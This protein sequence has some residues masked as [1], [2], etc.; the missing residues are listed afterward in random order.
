MTTTATPKAILG[1]LEDR[2]DFDDTAAQARATPAPAPGRAVLMLIAWLL[3]G[4]AF[5]LA[6]TIRK[7]GWM[8]RGLWT[9]LVWCRIILG[10]GW[11]QGW[12]AAEPR[13]A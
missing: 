3:F 2:V 9:A 6:W 4:P 5:T 10:K 8:L 7:A 13:H 11:R 12:A 1:T